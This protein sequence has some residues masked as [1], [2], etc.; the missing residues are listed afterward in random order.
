MGNP[1]ASRNNSTNSGYA[2]VNKSNRE[3]PIPPMTQ[4]N[5]VYYTSKMQGLLAVKDENEK[6]A[7]ILVADYLKTKSETVLDE[8]KLM[9][10][11][12]HM[13]QGWT[14]QEQNRILSMALINA[15]VTIA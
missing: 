12:E 6:K 4:K 5:G 13:L 14:V 8:K 11:L 9:Q 10:D 2:K 7:S 1:F 15:L 3:Y